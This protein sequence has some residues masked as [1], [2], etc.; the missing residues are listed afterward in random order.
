MRVRK[1][2]SSTIY[3]YRQ[4]YQQLVCMING[5]IHVF[6][7]HNVHYLDCWF[8]KVGSSLHNHI[9]TVVGDSSSFTESGWLAISWY[10][11]AC[12]AILAKVG[13]PDRCSVCGGWYRHKFAVINDVLIPELKGWPSKIEKIDSNH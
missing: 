4:M 7:T 13:I 12:Q 9:C 10:Q 6:L 5:M 8:H 2:M 11:D 3:A 1:A